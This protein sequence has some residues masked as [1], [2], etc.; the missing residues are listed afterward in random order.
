MT[1][2]LSKIV[3]QAHVTEFSRSGLFLDTIKCIFLSKMEA[4][5][6]VW[7]NSKFTKVT[8]KGHFQVWTFYWLVCADFKISQIAKI[9]LKINCTSL[10]PQCTQRSGR[11]EV[12]GARKNGRARG[13]HELL[14]I[15]PGQSWILDST[16]WIPDSIHRIPNLV[17]RTWIP[18]SIVSGIPDSK[19]CSPYAKA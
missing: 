10:P 5:L 4:P 12:L 15:W 16:V 8:T 9:A 14:P 19:S 17:S 3:D 2:N 6:S 7:A 13:R 1:G 18:D 11:A